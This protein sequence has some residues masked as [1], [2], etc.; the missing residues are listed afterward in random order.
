MRN[1]REHRD[2]RGRWWLRPDRSY[3]LARA[4]RQIAQTVSVRS[5]QYCRLVARDEDRGCGEGKSACRQRHGSRRHR[6]TATKTVSG[7]ARTSSPTLRNHVVPAERPAVI[8]TAAQTTVRTPASTIASDQT[9][10]GR[11]IWPTPSRVERTCVSSSMPD[12]RRHDRRLPTALP[13][14]RESA[15]EHEFGS[16]DPHE[17][18]RSVS[19]QRER[20]RAIGRLRRAARHTRSHRQRHRASSPS[21]QVSAVLLASCL[22]TAELRFC[23]VARLARR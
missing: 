12:R 10:A 11:T 5:R 7:A 23:E 15:L 9:A 20:L 1:D 8:A 4:A 18:K 19:G 14:M 22:G 2:E 21:E 3:E 13:R 16:E 6:S 17:L